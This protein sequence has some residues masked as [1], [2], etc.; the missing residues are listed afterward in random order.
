MQLV[1]DAYRHAV[2][3]SEQKIGQ[4]I[5]GTSGVNKAGAGAD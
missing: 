5:H 3:T 4:A 1:T 2:T